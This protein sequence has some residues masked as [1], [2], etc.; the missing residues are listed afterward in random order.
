MMVTNKPNTPQDVFSFK[1]AAPTYSEEVA[2][3]DVE[4][5]N[6]YPNPY[7]GMNPREQT[8]VD[9]FVS[10]NHLPNKVTF[11]IFDLAGN[12]VAKME[13]DDETQFARWDLRNHNGLPVASGIY[14]IHIDM[15]D[16]GKVKVLKLAL[17]REAEF[18]EVY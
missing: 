18:I 11:R 8:A 2:K 14:I 12:L 7:Y 6:V 9:R 13:K 17:V 4:K 15:P 3:A 16:L 1:S 5:I 10:F